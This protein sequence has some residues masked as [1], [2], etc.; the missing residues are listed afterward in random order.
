M[1]K[2]FKFFLEKEIKNWFLYLIYLISKLFFE[3]FL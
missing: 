2:Y 3:R 1:M